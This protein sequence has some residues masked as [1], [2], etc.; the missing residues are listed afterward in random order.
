MLTTFCG[1]F[2]PVGAIHCERRGDSLRETVPIPHQK[3]VQPT[4]FRVTT[5]SCRWADACPHIQGCF[6]R[7][8]CETP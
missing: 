6:F 8:R 3:L 2:P 4:L 1:C 5:H 7:T